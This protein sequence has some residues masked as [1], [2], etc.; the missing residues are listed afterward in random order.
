MKPFR[1]WVYRLLTCLL[2][3]SRGFDLKNALLRWAGAKIGSNVRVYSS[4]RIVGTGRLIIGDDVHIGSGVFISSIAPAEIRLGSQ[5]DIGPQVMILTGSHEIN[6]ENNLKDPLYGHIAGK[7]TEKSVYVG[8]GSW[9]GARSLILP[10]VTLARRTLVAAG[11]VVTRSSDKEA[12]ML[13]GSPAVE[14][15]IYR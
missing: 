8:N 1:L 2:P 13:A 6:V 14:K 10:G 4:A 7:G 5:I 3:E 9:L 11:S 12:A 15:K